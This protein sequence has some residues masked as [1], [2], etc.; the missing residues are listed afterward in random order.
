MA[1]PTEI[2]KST[3]RLKNAINR[4]LDPGASRTTAVLKRV[5]RQIAELNENFCELES[6]ASSSDSDL[7]AIL[8]ERIAFED[9][10]KKF[11][12]QF[13]HEKES[14]EARTLLEEQA[15]ETAL[16]GKTPSLTKMLAE[17]GKPVF[18]DRNS[19]TN[20]DHAMIERLKGLKK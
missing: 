2:I 4:L 12:D 6:Q 7:T 11:F 3:L 9:I 5:T 13:P 10:A 16:F 17:K 18:G 20:D 15:I 8:T 19:K 1:V 14:E